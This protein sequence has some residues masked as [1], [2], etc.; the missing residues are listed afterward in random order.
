[1][2]LIHCSNTDDRYSRIIHS[3]N[4]IAHGPFCIV[5]E[6]VS[7][8]NYCEKL[9]LSLPDKGMIK[10]YGSATLWSRLRI[11]ARLCNHIVCAYIRIVN[12]YANSI[13]VYRIKGLLNSITSIHNM[14]CLLTMLW[15]SLYTGLAQDNHVIHDR[16]CYRM[17]WLWR[18]SP[19]NNN[20]TCAWT[21]S[22]DAQFVFQ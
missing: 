12:Y 20:G 17:F 21:K 9:D 2:T 14:L 4:F 16:Y 18:I 6:Y 5:I 3:V 1:M 7:I 8:A 13:H 10:Y 19:L 22:I 11:S 15:D